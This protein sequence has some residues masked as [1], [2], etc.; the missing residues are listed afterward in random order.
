[1]ALTDPTPCDGELRVEVFGRSVACRLEMSM[2]TTTRPRDEISDLED[3]PTASEHRRWRRPVL[4]G[5]CGAFVVLLA[6]VSSSFVSALTTPGNVST[7]VRAVE[8]LRDHHG[9]WLVDHVEQWWYTHHPPPK[10]GRPHRAIVDP[11]PPSTDRSKHPSTS[12]VTTPSSPGYLPLPARVPSPAAQALAGEGV[13]NPAGPLINGHPGMYTTQIR[14]DAVHTSLLVGLVWIDPTLVRAELFPGL[15]Q[16]GGSLP[17]PHAVPPDQQPSLI[18]AFNSGFKMKDSRGGYY[19]NGM[20]VSPLVN[21]AA[22]FV[23]RKDGRATVGAWG[24]DV[25]MGP[26]IT[27]V[28]QNLVLIVDHHRAVPALDGT[29]H[30]LWGTTLGNSVMVWRSGVGIDAHGGLIYAAG[31]G[32]DARSLADVLVRAGAVRAMELDIN[33]FWVSFNFYQ[34][35]A[36]GQEAS[37][38][39]LPEMRRSASRYLSNDSRDFIALFRR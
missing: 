28:R 33:S 16:P 39:L 17:W 37:A 24:R 27:A 38:K 20:Q 31:P 29:D 21:G 22:S 11:S 2:L 15:S 6:V 32:L 7:S 8:W 19:E 30:R 23:I 14:P 3:P 1:L 9:V 10:G 26:D 34:H 4:L 12:T 5:V 35:T 18:A 36:A 25:H 13:W